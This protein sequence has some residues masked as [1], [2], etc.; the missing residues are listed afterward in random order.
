MSVMLEDS[1]YEEALVKANQVATARGT[2]DPAFIKWM[3][4]RLVKGANQVL[5]T[6][7]EPESDGDLTEVGTTAGPMLVVYLPDLAK[8]TLSSRWASKGRGSKKQTMHITRVTHKLPKAKPVPV[9]P[10]HRAPS[11]PSSPERMAEIE[12]SVKEAVKDTAA[13]PVKAKK[14]PSAKPMTAVRVSDIARSVTPKAP[15]Q[16]NAPDFSQ[17]KSPKDMAAAAPKGANKPHFESGGKQYRI[18]QKSGSVF[19][20]H[21]GEYWVTVTDPGHPGFGHPVLIREIPGHPG[22]AVTLSPMQGGTARGVPVTT[23]K[24]E[25]ALADAAKRREERQAARRE[26]AMTKTK[27]TQR[28][29]QEKLAERNAKTSRMAE[30]IAA[31]LSLYGHAPYGFCKNT[32]AGEK[33]CNVASRNGAVHLL[34]PEQIQASRAEG[35]KSLSENAVSLRWKA[36]VNAQAR[37]AG[38]LGKH[39]RGYAQKVANLPTLMSDDPEALSRFIDKEREER[40]RTHVMAAEHIGQ[41]ITKTE[42]KLKVAEEELARISK[43]ANSDKEPI[44]VTCPQ[45]FGNGKDGAKSCPLCKGAGQVS[46]E[47]ERVY[48]AQEKVDDLETSIATLADKQ[49]QHEQ[50]AALD[51]ASMPPLVLAPP[52]TR[53]NPRKQRQPEW[54]KMADIGKGDAEEWAAARPDIEIAL[55]ERKANWAAQVLFYRNEI[56]DAEFGRKVDA[57]SQI[58]PH[59]QRKEAVRG[60]RVMF[61]HA[62]E[63]DKAFLAAQEA[64][65]G[66]DQAKAMKAVNF[67]YQQEQRQP[68]SAIAGARIQ[69]QTPPHRPKFQETPSGKA[70]LGQIDPSRLAEMAKKDALLEREMTRLQGLYEPKNPGVEDEEPTIRDQ[71][72]PATPNY[73]QPMTPEEQ[74]TMLKQF[75]RDNLGSLISESVARAYAPV[76]AEEVL[77]LSGRGKE[78]EKILADARSEGLFAAVHSIALGLSRGA[79]MDRRITSLLG[80]AASAV[81]M[82][83]FV[84]QHDAERLPEMRKYL[85][86]WALKNT[87]PRLASAKEMYQSLLMDA[88]NAQTAMTRKMAS[89]QR[90]PQEPVRGPQAAELQYEQREMFE[91]AVSAIRHISSVWAEVQAVNTMLDSLERKPGDEMPVR[92]PAHLGF[93]RADLTKALTF[94][95]LKPVVDYRIETVN[96]EPLV[97]IKTAA[98]AKFVRPRAPLIDP[99]IAEQ[100]EAL[101]EGDESSVIKGFVPAGF[102]TVSHTPADAFEVQHAANVLKGVTGTNNLD[103]KVQDAIGTLAMYGL[104]HRQIRSLLHDEKLEANIQPAFRPTYNALVERYLP[105]GDYEADRRAAHRAHG[106]VN[107]VVDRLR[108]E[109]GMPPTAVDTQRLD[110]TAASAHLDAALKNVPFG[111]LAYKNVNDLSGTDRDALRRFWADEVAGMPYVVEK[112]D[113]DKGRQ[114]WSAFVKQVGEGEAL[115]AA[116]DLLK[117]EVI[118]QYLYHSTASQ[119][120][121][122][123]EGKQPVGIGPKMAEVPVCH[124]DKMDRAEFTGP[125]AG[126]LKRRSLGVVAE[127][128]MERMLRPKGDLA[129]RYDVKQSPV[130]ALPG[131][132]DMESPRWR[133]QQMAIRALP[134]AKRM[135]VVTDTGTGKTVIGLGGLTEL[136]AEGKVKRSAWMVP[137]SVVENYKLQGDLVRF[138]HNGSGLKWFAKAGASREERRAAMKSAEHNLY[139][140]TPESMREDLLDMVDEHFRDLDAPSTDAQK[141]GMEG[142]K[143]PEEAKRRREITLGRLAALPDDERS[144]IVH[145]AMKK[146]GIEFEHVFADE[147]H[148]LAEREGKAT[149]QM[150]LLD[151]AFTDGVPYFMMA[152][153]SPAQNDMSEA[154]DLTRKVRP[155]LFVERKGQEDSPY[156]WLRENYGSL[157]VAATREETTRKAARDPDPLLLQALR[158]EI[159]PL[160]FMATNEDENRPN[161]SEESVTLTAGQ[162]DALEKVNRAAGKAYRIDTQEGRDALRFLNPAAFSRAVKQPDGT[163]QTVE[164][165][166]GSTEEF[167]VGAKQAQALET[168]RREA[169]QHV[170][171]DLPA[172]MNAKTQHIAKTIRSGKYVNARTGRPASGLVFTNRVEAATQVAADLNDTAKKEGWTNFRAYALDFTTPP[173]E[174]KKAEEDYAESMRIGRQVV[175]VASPAHSESKD[176]PG[177]QWVI[178]YDL[179][180]TLH[181]MNQREGRLRAAINKNGE[182]HATRLV[183]HYRDKG[184]LHKHETELAAEQVVR[185]KAPTMR[186]FRRHRHVALSDDL[187][188]MFAANK[189]LRTT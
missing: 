154:M 182:L 89:Y 107:R 62:K 10:G 32:D 118:G 61:N 30:V 18:H 176:Y 144:R 43:T 119:V 147:W 94:Y 56:A 96:E 87:Y 23:V 121:A 45:C 120:R 156:K 157:G 71:R 115:L 68:E 113:E 44:P 175:L 20:V 28:Q 131:R 132:L 150:T 171:H 98:M 57:K 130:S 166:R 26:G 170:L 79:M 25:Q 112:G 24:T 41:T 105:S 140:T 7:Q 137:R 93:D 34:T 9:L 27:Y 138:T 186:L 95:G 128:Q 63:V 103:D 184:Q 75:A 139:I 76:E 133:H 38:M 143:T 40:A 155:D 47:E 29:E 54:R 16:P 167:K 158:R 65:R 48:E 188:R 101:Q 8:A 13:P 3:A 174:V 162:M 122:T 82:R 111:H 81:A 77:G 15:A 86:D 66:D 84:E 145:A 39:F 59:I 114:A 163:N 151:T 168:L 80:P 97:H 127:Q 17:Y 134:I 83:S 73:G 180:H 141:R 52:E 187:T 159:A 124:G 1:V 102:R 74:K 117:D 106:F 33:G 88:R 6:I 135:A 67:A 189:L 109:R 125:R 185:G 21:P 53:L 129:S 146:Q 14:A 183:A 100:L 181:A 116:Q 104:S 78:E 142:P 64:V 35:E 60:L 165:P 36:N 11:T 177:G 173:S 72:L 12:R 123:P 148:R 161:Y 99:K 22:E 2:T 91:R 169:T 51:T 90:S 58:P 5:Y 108:T 37:F 92:V 160:V 126:L 85:D 42:A 69:G 46:R 178:H 164:V 55:A 49:K 110:E 152:T 4:A 50:L 31:R 172:A 70:K 153:A 136:M 149:S 179:P 19:E